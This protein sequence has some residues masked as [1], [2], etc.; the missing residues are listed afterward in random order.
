MAKEMNDLLLTTDEDLAIQGGDFVIAE[1]T[2]RHQQ[3]LLLNNKGD[4]KENP[5]VG[6]GV[7]RYIDDEDYRGLIRAVQQEYTRDGMEAVTVQLD[8]DGTIT[9]IA[10][11]R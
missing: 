11:Y 2:A 5:T 7:F 3:Q 9:G 6:V 10:N 4:Y 8:K 1:A